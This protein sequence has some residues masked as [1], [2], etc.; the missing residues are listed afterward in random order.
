MIRVL[1]VLRGRAVVLPA[2]VQAAELLLGLLL[3]EDVQVGAVRRLNS[4]DQALIVR[5][6]VLRRFG[7]IVVPD[8]QVFEVFV[9]DVRVVSVLRIREDLLLLLLKIRDQIVQLFLRLA[10]QLFVLQHF[11]ISVAQLWIDILERVGGWVIGSERTRFL[12]Q[13]FLFVH[14]LLGFFLISGASLHRSR[15]I[16]TY[17]VFTDFADE[18]N[19]F[20]DVCDVVD[21]ALLDFEVL[22]GLVQVEGLLGRLLEQ[23][24][25]FFG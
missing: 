14:L 13:T 21:A 5:D 23:I 10:Q 6:A 20:E 3:V 24:N 7:A 9:R 8:R 25:E 15:S 2:R 4:Y 19:A 22:H 17:I 18:P 11:Q 16:P 12:G 1:H